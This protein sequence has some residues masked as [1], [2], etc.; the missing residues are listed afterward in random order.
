MKSA[1][2]ILNYNSYDI[3]KKLALHLYNNTSIEH[4]LIVD[5]NSTNDS[6]AQLKLICNDRIELLVSEVNKGYAAGNNIGCRYA[7]DHHKADILFIANPDVIFDQSFVDATKEELSKKSAIVAVTGLMF[8][9]DGREDRRQYL[10]LPRYWED[11]A[12][13]FIL[14]RKFVKCYLDKKIKVDKFKPIIKAD[15]LPGSLFVI[16]ADVF[17]EIGFF[18]ENTFLYYEENILGIKLKQHNYEMGLL[19]NCKYLHNHAATIG[20][21]VK[22]VAKRKI[23]NQS[24]LYY[25][26]TYRGTSGF[27]RLILEICLKLSIVDAFIVEKIKNI[28]R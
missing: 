26:T 11:I 25:E 1:I 18:D 13:C 15:A 24:V 20:K 19:T 5:N 22:V 2:I 8:Y 12:N 10:I 9:P 7:I 4:I 6:V 28:K 16:R 23:V 27:K 17:K 14:G 3:S 21:Y